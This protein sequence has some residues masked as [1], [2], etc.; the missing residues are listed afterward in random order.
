M[1]KKTKVVIDS[2]V[3]VSAFGWHG[4]PKELMKLVTAGKITN[5]TSV[6]MLE[7]L[8]RVIAYPNYEGYEIPYWGEGG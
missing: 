2:N 5:Y 7:E 1:G 8:S 6:A 4:T 3:L